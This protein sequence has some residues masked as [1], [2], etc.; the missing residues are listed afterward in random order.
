[1]SERIEEIVAVA[2][3][4]DAVYLLLVGYEEGDGGNGTGFLYRTDGARVSELQPVLSTNDY[5]RAMWASPEG[6]IWLSSEDGNVWTDADAKWSKAKDRELASD[7]Y[8]PKLKW[9][10]TTLP[11]PHGEDGTPTLGAIWGTGDANVFAAASE[12]P[13]YQW[14]GKNWRQ[15]HVAAG[16]IRAFAGTGP[17]DVF[18][19]G[20]QGALAHFDGT[21]WQTLNNP[22]DTEGDELF[23]GACSDAEGSVYICS[24]N[25]RL[26][27]G[28]GSGLTVLAQDANLSLRGLALL[29][30][31]LLLAAGD[32]GVAEL[33]VSTLVVVRSTFH[34]TYIV[35]GKARLF[36]LDASTETCYVEYD[37]AQDEMP[38]CFVAF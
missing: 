22:D 20:E 6:S 18:A 15:V 16:T 35:A 24:Q 31:R 5:L 36:F 13:I 27:H 19:V 29:G 12:G 23:T 34:S 8:D 30:D 3:V 10:V 9:K 38:W 37:P 1:M 4:G 26:L 33:Q 2:E 25:G 11:S 14:N 7:S 17:S 21:A 28:S 32:G